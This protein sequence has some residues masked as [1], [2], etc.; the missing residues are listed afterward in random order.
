MFDESLSRLAYHGST[1]N[2]ETLIKIFY[3]PAEVQKLL[4]IK[5]TKFWS[6]VKT[7]KIETRK[8]G[9]A[10][11]IPA[12]SLQKFVANLPKADEA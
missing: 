9:R 12:E 4:S 10:T 1:C 2:P 7:G 3:R 6:L 8:L 11:L 5:N